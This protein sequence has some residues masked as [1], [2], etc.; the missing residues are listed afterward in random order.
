MI[1][2]KIQYSRYSNFNEAI[3]QFE[4]DKDINDIFGEKF[5]KTLVA[6]RKVEYLAYMEVVSPWER[7]YLLLNV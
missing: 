6:M 7:E 2:C 3:L 5:V 4:Q 1:P